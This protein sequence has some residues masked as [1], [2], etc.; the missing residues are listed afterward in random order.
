[1][2]YLPHQEIDGIFLTENGL[3]MA[4]FYAQVASFFSLRVDTIASN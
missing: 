4:M 3:K 1:M 2:G